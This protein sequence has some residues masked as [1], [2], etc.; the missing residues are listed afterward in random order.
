MY[1]VPPRW[2]LAEDIA[3]LRVGSVRTR[4]RGFPSV[5]PHDGPQ[6]SAKGI[7]CRPHGIPGDTNA[8]GIG[9][10]RVHSMQNLHEMSH[11]EEAATPYGILAVNGRADTTHHRLT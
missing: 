3:W 1:N 5:C 2:T 7:H 8:T 11:L 4:E 10:H 6:R 9:E